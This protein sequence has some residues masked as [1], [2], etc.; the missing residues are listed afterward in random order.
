MQFGALLQVIRV[1]LL[2]GHDRRLL[3]LFQDLFRRGTETNYVVCRELVLESNA[4]EVL[5][6]AQEFLLLAVSLGELP[7]IL[8]EFVGAP[9]QTE[10]DGVST[11]IIGELLVFTFALLPTRRHEREAAADIQRR[12]SRRQ[13]AD[14]TLLAEDRDRARAEACVVVGRRLPHARCGL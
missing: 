11:E 5:L 12:D 13:G 2:D 4:V 8:K 14:E 6:V 7:V 10:V 9:M 3:L 1:E